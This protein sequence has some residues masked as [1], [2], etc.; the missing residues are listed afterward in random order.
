MTV[1]G[2]QNQFAHPGIPDLPAPRRTKKQV[3]DDVNEAIARK[4]DADRLYTNNLKRLAAFKKRAQADAAKA[5]K[6]ATGIGLHID[7]DVEMEGITAPVETGNVVMG[8]ENEGVALI[9]GGE[10]QKG[11]V[12]P[13]TIVLRD[14]I[15]AHVNMVYDNTEV[16]DK[17]RKA[18]HV[19]GRMSKKSKPA[20]PTGLLPG[21]R[22]NIPKTVD[23]DGPAQAGENGP[24]GEI[25]E[26]VVDTE[27]ESATDPDEE[28]TL[29]IKGK[30]PNRGKPASKPIGTTTSDMHSELEQAT[31]TARTA[32]AAAYHDLFNDAPED[33][34][35][36][37]MLIFG[38]LQDEDDGDEAPGW[39]ADDTLNSPSHNLVE[40]VD[41]NSESESEADEPAMD[42]VSEPV[43]DLDL[44]D[45]ADTAGR[46]SLAKKGTFAYYV[47]D[48]R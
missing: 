19:K 3:E 41:V 44:E 18:M 22:K 24:E 43:A 13:R 6:E 4:E 17:K 25:T 21:W 48:V 31:V 23:E 10:R 36:E 11:V 20:L 9:K 39:L 15:S 38:G 40:I 45:V 46:V 29:K 30:L 37:S 35:T 33:S 34:N 42:G 28:K 8:Q 32:R 26:E 1:T 2:A 14:L 47:D 16:I 12:R 27:V 5:A 7:E